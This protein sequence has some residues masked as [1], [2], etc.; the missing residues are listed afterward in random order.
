[1]LTPDQNSFNTHF[2]NELTLGWEKEIKWLKIFYDE[3]Q[4]FNLEIS[5][6]NL[7]RNLDEQSIF[8]INLILSR[9]N[10]IVARNSINLSTFGDDE[11]I[12]AKKLKKFFYGNILKLNENCYALNKYLMPVSYFESC[13]FDEK[14]QLDTLN[15]SY[16]RDKDIIDG[17]AYIGDSA[18]VF[19]D[20]TNKNVYSFEPVKQNYSH[21]LK[22]IELN[23]K[24]NIVPINMGL[25]DEKKECEFYVD[26]TYGLSH[27][28]YYNPKSS[29]LKEKVQ[30]I[31]LDEYVSEQK[32]NV[33]LIKTDLEGAEQDFLRG[34]EKTIRSM[35][36]TLLISLYHNANDFFNIKPLI[37]SWDLGY[38]FRITAP[39][40][41]RVISETMLV[42]EM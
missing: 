29:D 36:P 31:T 41:C 20:Y 23:E 18:L 24:K 4:K 14:H 15:T 21:M 11:I 10:K 12:E 27:S 16:F 35:K 8:R 22:T 19:S 32:L 26:D 42:A 3:M 38:K 25:S 2:I 5:Y 17:G 40:P 13:V 37:E 9:I 6:K 39:P 28:M 1:M 34:A 33:G 30:L 7:V